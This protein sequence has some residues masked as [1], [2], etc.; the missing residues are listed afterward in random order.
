MA[1]PD[2]EGDKRLLVVIPCLNEEEHLPGLLAWLSARSEPR[3]IVVADGGSTDD[4][5]RI[6]EGAAKAD[7]RIVLIDNPQRLQSAGVN[8][9]VRAFSAEADRFVRIDAHAA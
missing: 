6:V 5:R 2:S 8:A 9:A 7:P 3:R 1:G 4:S